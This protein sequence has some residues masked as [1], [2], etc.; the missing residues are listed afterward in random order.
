[1]TGCSRPYD[2][3]STCSRSQVPVTL[4]ICPTFKIISN[5]LIQA[6]VASCL[7][8]TVLNVCGTHLQLLLALS[9]AHT[10]QLLFKENTTSSLQQAFICTRV[11]QSNAINAGLPHSLSRIHQFQSILNSRVQL[12]LWDSEVWPYI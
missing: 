10:D 7:L 4:S 12:K 1:M 2:D 6:M 11:D 9:Q 3:L 8:D 5:S